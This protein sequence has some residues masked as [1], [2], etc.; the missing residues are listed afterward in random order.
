MRATWATTSAR[1]VAHQPDHGARRLRQLVLRHAQQ[2]L[3]RRTLLLQRGVVLRNASQRDDQIDQIDHNDQMDHND[4]RQNRQPNRHRHQR[5]KRTMCIA[6]AYATRPIDAVRTFK[7]VTS[8]NTCKQRRHKKNNN[9][10]KQ[11][12]LPNQFKSG[13]LLQRRAV[14]CPAPRPNQ[15][16]ARI[17]RAAG[18]FRARFELGERAR[19]DVDVDGAAQPQRRRSARRVARTTTIERPQEMRNQHAVRQRVELGER[20]A[21]AVDAGRRRLKEAD[22]L[23]ARLLDQLRPEPR[24]RRAGVWLQERERRDEDA[25]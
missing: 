5:D 18:V 4:R 17:T 10:N 16:S 15:R 3:S 8:D 2:A 14:Q 6:S 25:E 13:R 1:R 24:R 9:N 11:Q 7:R 20:R 12:Q 23:G 19:I 22:E 21:R